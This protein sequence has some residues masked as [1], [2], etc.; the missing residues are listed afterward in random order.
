M[1]KNSHPYQNRKTNSVRYL[2]RKFNLCIEIQ[3]KIG[4]FENIKQLLIPY[5]IYDDNVV[6][7]A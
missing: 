6:Y 7:I 3:L 5:D 2:S 4:I 1:G